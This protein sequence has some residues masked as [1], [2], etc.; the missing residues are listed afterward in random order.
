MRGDLDW[1][2]M[3]ALE[4]DRDRRYQSVAELAADLR[5]YAAGRPVQARPSLYRSALDRQ[6]RRHLDQVEANLA[7]QGGQCAH[8][9]A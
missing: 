3:K 2:V 8:Q 1:I 5:R 6:L 7:R 9:R 4:K